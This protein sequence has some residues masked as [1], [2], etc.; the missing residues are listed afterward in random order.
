MSTISDLQLSDQTFLIGAARDI[1]AYTLSQCSV[2]QAFVRKV[3]IN[4]SQLSFGEEVFD[5]EDYDRVRIVAAGKAAAPMLTSL[6]GRLP[7][8]V[9]CDIAGVLA[10]P[11]LPMNLPPGFVSF[12]SGHPLPNQD[13]L[14]AARAARDLL[15]TLPRD[16]EIAGRTLCIFL[17]SGG[18]SAMLEEPLDTTISLED[19]TAFHR[20]LVHSGAS[21][22]EINCV[23]KHFSAVKGGRLALAAPRGATL[24]AFFVSDVPSMQ[25]AELGSGP[26]LPDP[27]T[28]EQCRAV[29]EHY[30][31]L[32]Q[33]PVS[34]R[35]FF[36]QNAL[37]ETPKPG[38]LHL[39]YCTLLD[40]SDLIAAARARAVELGFRVAVDNTCDDWE[41][42]A[43]AR[44]LLERL[45][46]LRQIVPIPAASNP[47]I[48]TPPEPAPNYICL[49]SAGEVAVR[50]EEPVGTGGRNQQFALYAATQ[51]KPEDPPVTVLSA[52]SDGVDGNSPAAG[53]IVDPETV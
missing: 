6:L 22:G 24:L 15:V 13:S 46:A 7:V 44:Y 20:V 25:L 42:M 27:T 23:R 12:A 49:L 36:M 10:A 50:V 41:Y 53:G 30:A 52:G 51:I 47:G 1:F 33:F 40:S 48:H 31:L 16:A 37:P 5:L 14:K 29:L 26:V 38:M 19:T 43:A 39:S 17:I 34:V 4:G 45:R 3:A 35:R 18:A 2:E 32:D 8:R 9:D 28:V 21:I 11:Q